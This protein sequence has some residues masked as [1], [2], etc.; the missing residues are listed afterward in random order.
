MTTKQ[1]VHT[2]SAPAAIGPYSQAIVFG[3]LMFVSGQIPLDPASGEVVKGGLE[4]QTKRVLDNLKAILKAQGLSLEHV[5][6][7]TIFLRDMASFAKVNEVYQ[8]YFSQ[9]Y[10]ARS[11]VAVAGLPKDVPVEIE[12]IVGIP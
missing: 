12:A 9:P 2:A 6:K 4:E 1:A 10:P 7:T 3:K 11:T 5:L 8:G